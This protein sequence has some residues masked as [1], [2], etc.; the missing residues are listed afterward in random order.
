MI[1]KFLSSKV[2]IGVLAGFLL[3]ILNRKLG[4]ELTES[5]IWQALGAIGIGCGAEGYRDAHRSNGT[6]PAP[7]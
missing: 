4:L 6:P 3:P 7:K 1:T 5:D 2:W